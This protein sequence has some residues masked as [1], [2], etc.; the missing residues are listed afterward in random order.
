MHPSAYNMDFAHFTYTPYTKATYWLPYERIV[1]QKRKCQS[2]H[3]HHKK[4][5]NG[6][7]NNI[8]FF[9][10]NLK[11][12]HICIKDHDARSH[13]ETR[14]HQNV[15]PN[16]LA[17]SKCIY[18]FAACKS[19]TFRTYKMRSKYY[20]IYSYILHIRDMSTCDFFL[21][22]FIQYHSF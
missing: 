8:F 1:M 20:T 18:T 3:H 12:V 10:V 11:Y 6:L 22:L 17:T 14:F 4:G 19:I 5:A 2:G 15:R 7:V 9:F 13:P 21:Y 16:L